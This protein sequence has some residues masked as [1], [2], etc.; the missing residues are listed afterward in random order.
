MLYYSVDGDG[1]SQLNSGRARV[2]FSR[3]E[4]RMAAAVSGQDGPFVLLAP[5]AAP[6]GQMAFQLS[7]FLVALEFRLPADFHR[8]VVLPPA[9]ARALRGVSRGLDQPDR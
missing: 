5:P 7:R 9:G 1:H 2:R 8:H 3:R 4:G 6:V